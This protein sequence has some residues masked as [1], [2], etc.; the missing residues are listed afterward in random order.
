MYSFQA[1]LHA[2]GSICGVDR[3]EDQMKLDDQAE[4]RLKR[5]VYVVASNSPKLTPSVR[6]TTISLVLSSAPHVIIIC[7]YTGLFYWLARLFFYQF[8]SKIQIFG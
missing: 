6:A 8:Y 1:A 4:E 7:L 3:Q 5:L 2:F